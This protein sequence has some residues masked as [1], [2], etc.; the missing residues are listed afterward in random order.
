MN[1]DSAPAYQIWWECAHPRR[2]N[3]TV[4][5]FL[6]NFDH[7]HR[8]AMSPLTL[9]ELTFRCDMYIRVRKYYDMLLSC[10]WSLNFHIA[11]YTGLWYTSVSCAWRRVKRNIRINVFSG[12]DIVRNITSVA[13][14]LTI[15]V[16][17]AEFLCKKCWHKY[18]KCIKKLSTETYAF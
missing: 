15:Y 14:K 6:K 1:D 2:R 18:T 12:Y 10:S 4:V 11:F 8:N 16:G 9:L 3:D 7:S 5:I 13:L 17:L